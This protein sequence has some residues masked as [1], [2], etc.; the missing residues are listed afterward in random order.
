V[1]LNDG[2]HDAA[3]LAREGNYPNNLYLELSK[4]LSKETKKTL[5]T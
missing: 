1:D 4:R 5:L 3:D 2:A